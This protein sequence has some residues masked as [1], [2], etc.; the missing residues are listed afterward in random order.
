MI[1]FLVHCISKND[2]FVLNRDFS[3]STTHYC[4]ITAFTYVYW[5]KPACLA[6]PIFLISTKLMGTQQATP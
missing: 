6:D 5:V 3:M 1:L 2:S 4:F